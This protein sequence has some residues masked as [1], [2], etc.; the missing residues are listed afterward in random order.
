MLKSLFWDGGIDKQLLVSCLR[1]MGGEG[2]LIL[3]EM[4]KYRNNYEGLGQ[5]NEDVIAMI[6]KVLGWRVRPR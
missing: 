4:M 6:A 3:L 5:I 1:C 2:E